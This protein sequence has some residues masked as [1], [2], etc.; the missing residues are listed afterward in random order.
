MNKKGSIGAIIVVAMTIFALGIA[1]FATHYML[2]YSVDAITNTSQVNE[3]QKAIE[4]FNTIPTLTNK[5]DYVIFGIFMGM[6]LALIITSYF[7]SGHAIFMAVYFIAIV[8][9]IILSAIL[10]NTWETVTQMSIFGTTILN[11]PLTNNLVMY[12][13]LYLGIVGIVAMF[14]MFG[15]PFMRNV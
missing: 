6:L 8:L 13:P 1:F 11:F 14:I 9:G 10:A 5:L 4:S 7:I 3:S 12:M 2:N 15:K